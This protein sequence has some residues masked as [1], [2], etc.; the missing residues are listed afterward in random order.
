MIAKMPRI[1]KSCSETLTQKKLKRKENRNA[2]YA[3]LLDHEKKKMKENFTVTAV[4]VKVVKKTQIN[5]TI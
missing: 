3:R 4:T 2:P 5:V 1:Q